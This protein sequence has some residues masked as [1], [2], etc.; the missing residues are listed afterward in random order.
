MCLKVQIL[1][2]SRFVLFKI[3]LSKVLL[4]QKLCD[5]TYGDNTHNN[6]GVASGSDN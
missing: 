5:K 4:C 6:V 3:L 1:F 2:Y